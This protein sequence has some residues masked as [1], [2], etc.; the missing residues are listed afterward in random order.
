MSATTIYEAAGDPWKTNIGPSINS[1][2]SDAFPSFTDAAGYLQIINV[3]TKEMAGGLISANYPVPAGAKFFGLDTV[4]WISTEDFPHLARHENDLKVTFPGGA[5]ANGSC[6]WNDDKKI[7]QLGAND[8][9]GWVDTIYAQPVVVGRNKMQ[10]RI[11]FDGSKW[12]ITGLRVNDDQNPLVPGPA[13]QN[14][15]AAASGWGAGL[16]PQLQ[17]ECRKVPWYLRESYQRVRVIASDS[18]IPWSQD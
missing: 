6:Q 1:V 17:T 18:A 13:F 7:W 16:H 15:P 3:A 12:S 8:G 9:S 14:L 4:W 2:P 5:Q 11:A 10:L